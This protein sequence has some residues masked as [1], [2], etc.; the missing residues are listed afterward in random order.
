MSSLKLTQF[1]YLCDPLA[2]RDVTTQLDVVL[3]SQAVYSSMPRVRVLY[4]ERLI[5][6]KVIEVIG[7][8]KVI[9]KL[10]Y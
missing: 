2:K 8:G 6:G 7:I 3:D 10:Y 9:E 4:I 1:S 5:I